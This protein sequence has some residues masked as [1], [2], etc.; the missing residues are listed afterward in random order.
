MKSNT[1]L[2]GLGGKSAVITGAS[3][4]IGC[5]IADGFVAA[6]ACVALSYRN[7][8]DALSGVVTRAEALGQRAKLYRVNASNND[9]VFASA[10]RVL[11][12]FGK[13]DVLVNCIGGNIADAMTNENRRF[14]D[15]DVDAIEETMRLNFITGTVLPCVAF[16]RIIAQNAAGGSL[17][18]I[19]SMNSYRPLEGRPAYAA[20]KAAVN[21]FT[22]WLAAHLAKEYSPALRVN[23][24]APGFFPNERMRSA[25]FD[26]SGQPTERTRRIVA[27][28]PM[29]RLGEVED[30]VG[31]AIWY[32][33]EASRFVTGT[34]TA[35]DGGFNS[36]AGV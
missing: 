8:P 24:I 5:A 28:T 30:L 32:A 3:G 18:N 19:S 35:V 23:A 1:D 11:D 9:E 33:T 4:A 26:E 27:H 29:G 25:L 34:I 20:S 17:I 13:V 16:G 14:F 21:N 22:Q 36:Y 10:D 15:L 6:G 2:F 31:T 12:D 7:N